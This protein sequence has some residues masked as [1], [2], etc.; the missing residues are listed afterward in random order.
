MVRD[1]SLEL[2]AA[3]ELDMTAAFSFESR[4]D[5]LLSAGGVQA[6]VVDLAQV[7]FVDPLGSAPCCRSAITRAG[8]GSTS[9]SPASQILSASSST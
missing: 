6:V 4:V 1:S 8:A 2:I 5:A 9:N 7:D 3:G